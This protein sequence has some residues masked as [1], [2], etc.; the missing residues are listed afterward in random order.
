MSSADGL[1]GLLAFAASFFYIP[2]VMNNTHSAYSPS[3]NQITYSDGENLSQKGPLAIADYVTEL[4]S[5]GTRIL[6]GTR[7]TFWI[8]HESL[9]LIRR[10]FTALH[11]LPRSFVRHFGAVG[12]RF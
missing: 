10:R 2:D 12:L 5:N 6:P 8:Q 4:A 7:E 11:R 9:A 1:T 3:Y